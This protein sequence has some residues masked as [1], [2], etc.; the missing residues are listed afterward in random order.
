MAT[1][2]YR[3]G[4]LEAAMRHATAGV[5]LCSRLA[6]TQPLADGLATLAWIRQAEGDSAGAQETIEEARNIAP[7]PEVADLLNPVPAMQARILLAQGDTDAAARWTAERGVAIDDD[8]TYPREPAYLVLARILLE[9][10]QPD[11]ALHLLDRLHTDAEGRMGSVIEIQMLR[12]LGMAAKSEEDAAAAT[13]AESLTLAHPQGHIRVFAD[14]GAPMAHLLG[15]FIAKQGADG[16]GADVPLPFVSRLVSAFAES[17][18]DSHPSSRL[19][20]PGLVVPLTQRE[21][22]VLELLAA[23]KRNREIADEIYVSLNTVKKHATHIFDKLGATNRTE[24]VTRARQ[25]G[26]IP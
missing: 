3:R 1:V 13:L 21:V 10:E 16:I 18:A 4:D 19:P 15:V 23:G 14:E 12:A 24:A 20:V 22:E 11:Q 9:R 6:Y 5:E 8:P 25:L 2:F 26:L 7:G 17:S